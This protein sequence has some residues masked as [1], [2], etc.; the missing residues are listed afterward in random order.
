M[1]TSAI[2]GDGQPGMSA[3]GAAVPSVSAALVQT[4]APPAA[5]VTATAFKPAPERGDGEDGEGGDTPAGEADFDDDDME[6]LLSLAVIEAELKPKVV[7]TFD[8]K[9]LRRLQDQDIQNKLRNDSL[10]PAQPRR[11][12]VGWAESESTPS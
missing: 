4:P 11:I 2:G 10:S 8:N 5:P 6:N 12:G 1:P 9:R 3:P 7:A